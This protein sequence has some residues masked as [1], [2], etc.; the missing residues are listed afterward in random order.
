LSDRCHT[1]L[2]VG[3]VLTDAMEVQTCTVIR[4]TVGDVD[5]DSI[6]PVCFDRWTYR[7][8]S[9]SQHGVS[10]ITMACDMA[11]RFVILDLPLKGRYVI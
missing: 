11:S 9:S 1:I 8:K 5:F 10:D 7:A 6:T 4:K 3:I 2:R